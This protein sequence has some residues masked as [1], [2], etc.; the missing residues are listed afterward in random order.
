MR[1]IGRRRNPNQFGH[2]Y[3]IRLQ[4]LGFP[5]NSREEFEEPACSSRV[6]SRRCLLKILSEHREE[7]LASS[8]ESLGR[9]QM[10]VFGWLGNM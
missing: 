4:A 5:S 10:T 8:L 2:E 7:I 6:S 9:W 3:G 1:T